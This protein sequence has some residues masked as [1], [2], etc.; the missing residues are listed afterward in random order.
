MRI[1][2]G[3]SHPKQV[4][5]FKNLI[6]IME[7]RGHEFEVVVVEKEMTRH[8][9]EQFNIPY[10]LIGE[11]QSTLLK[12]ILNLPLWEYRTLKIAN[13]FKPDIFIGQALP[14]LAHVSALLNKPFIVFEDTEHAEKLHKIV[15]PFANA[16]VTPDCYRND[17]GEKQIRFDGYFELAYLHP[18]HFEPNPSVLHDLNLGE[19]DTFIIMR[20][21][22][23]HAYHDI[24]QSGLDFEAKQKSVREFEKYGRVFITSENVLPKEFEKYMLNVSSEMIHHLMYYATLYFGESSTM[25]TETGI[26]G[27]PS[28]YVSSLVGTMGNFEELEK[29]YELVY[30]FQDP[31]L[32]LGKALELLDDNE[33]KEK[34]KKKR[35]KLLEG[36]VDVTK[37][38]TEFIESYPENFNK[39][40]EGRRED[41]GYY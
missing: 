15:L 38:M 12:K 18:N 40:K 17:L 8:L 33:I 31:K 24:G 30:S 39:Y 7:S 2:V 10:K 25:A 11:N 4:Y 16:V 36:K 1:L 23:W 32:A 13:K 35:E 22:S 37:F 14:H 27:T 20:F 9:L 28:I 21:V 41:A 29:K 19:D 6:E 3:I 26:L 34:W 5:M